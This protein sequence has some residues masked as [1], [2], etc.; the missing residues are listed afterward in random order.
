MRASRNDQMT[1]HHADGI[2]SE[3]AG[4]DSVNSTIGAC[5]SVA[6]QH[7][8]MKLIDLPI[9]R[10]WIV[11]GRNDH[12]DQKSTVNVQAHDLR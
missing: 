7:W 9:N 4:L 10:I 11:Q 3:E 8:R 1:I 12:S 6:S 5:Q 2:P